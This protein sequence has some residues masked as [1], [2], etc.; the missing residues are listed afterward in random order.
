ML[1]LKIFSAQ[2][3]CQLHTLMIYNPTITED[4]SSLQYPCYT[5]HTEPHFY[6]YD[7]MSY[8]TMIDKGCTD[9]KKKHT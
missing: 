5:N 7:L 2:I 1:T 8:I 6:N 3:W 9:L 4:M